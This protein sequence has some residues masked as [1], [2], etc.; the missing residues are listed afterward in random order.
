MQHGT[1]LTGPTRQDPAK[2][3][4][5]EIGKIDNSGGG[6]IKSA[7]A[8]FLERATNGRIWTILKFR[9]LGPF[10][11]EFGHFAFWGEFPP[12]RRPGGFCH[13]R[14][15]VGMPDMVPTWAL[16]TFLCNQI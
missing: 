2:Q 7:F 12:F 14:N 16:S 6:L 9:H 8:R 4:D 3:G 10:W 1:V 15:L 5:L 11:G 13:K